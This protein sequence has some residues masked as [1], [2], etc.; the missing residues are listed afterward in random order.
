MC[1]KMLHSC[2]SPHAPAPDVN[3]KWKSD[4]V[5][6][7]YCVRIGSEP[8]S[9]PDSTSDGN[10]VIIALNVRLCELRHMKYLESVLKM[11]PSYCL[12]DIIA[13]RIETNMVFFHGHLHTIFSGKKNK[14]FFLTFI[15]GSGE[16]KSSKVC[17]NATSKTE[18]WDNQCPK[19]GQNSI[20]KYTLSHS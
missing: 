17:K 13:K 6:S 5:C 14:S 20:H 1:S 10:I 12:T 7:R 9:R 19:Y 16:R 8:K 2:A 3:E 18:F 11:I 4:E 15:S